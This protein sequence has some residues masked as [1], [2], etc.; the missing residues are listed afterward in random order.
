MTQAEENGYLKGQLLIAMPALLD[1]NFHQ[2]VTCMAEHNRDGAMGIVVNRVHPQIRAE[3]IY[4]ELEIPFAP[5]AGAAPVHVG[6]PVHSGEIF[7]LHGP[8]LEWEASLTITP[9]LAMSNTIDLLKAVAMEKGPSAYLICLGCA[10]WAPGQLEEEIKQ[11]AWLNGPVEEEI[12]FSLAVE[13]RWAAA[14]ERLGFHPDL[15][16]G[17]AGH[18]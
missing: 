4:R 10:G 3:D 7:I 5:E 15:L 9:T 11:N 17:T 8:P 18:A 1:P 14:V 2:T 12:L 16:S 6:G 13:H